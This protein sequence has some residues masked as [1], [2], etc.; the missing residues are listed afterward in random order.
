MA[1]FADLT[2]YSY[3]NVRFEEGSAPLINVGWLAADHPFPTAEPEPE[4]VRALLR[5]CRRPVLLYRGFHVCDLCDV[6]AFDMQ[7]VSYEGRRV[8]VGNGE[9]CVQGPDGRWYT[10]PTLVAHYVLTHHYS[11]PE[12]FISGV[13]KAAE[14]IPS[15]DAEE[16][17][18]LAALSISER[19]ELCI[20]LLERENKTLA[21]PWV[22]R[23]INS[24]STMR[25]ALAPKGWG[26][27]LQ[28]IT[29]KSRFDAVNRALVLPA[30]PN[31][32]PPRW[33]HDIARNAM[34]ILMHARSTDAAAETLEFTATA[35]ECAIEREEDFPEF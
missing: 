34:W 24:L 29:F 16:L 19:F 22:A 18:Q 14:T 27:L 25:S 35:L 30:N 28:G 6:Q 26:K 2:E 12:Q 1:Y 23:V 31:D 9:V 33:M 7:V 20:D 13:L 11:P 5:C 15:I 21:N 8:H 3:G 10:A 17:S 4:F 32:M